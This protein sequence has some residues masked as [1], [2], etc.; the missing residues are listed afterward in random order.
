MQWINS[1][2]PDAS[3]HIAIQKIVP[4][5]RAEYCAL[6][7]TSHC[8]TNGAQHFVVNR[9]FLVNN[10][11]LVKCFS[12]SCYTKSDSIIES[13][14]KAFIAPKIDMKCCSKILSCFLY[15]AD[16]CGKRTRDWTSKTIDFSNFWYT[17]W[18]RTTQGEKKNQLHQMYLKMPEYIVGQA[19]HN[20]LYF[21]WF[22]ISQYWNG[23]VLEYI[24]DVKCD[25]LFTSAHW[26]HKSTINEVAT[27]MQ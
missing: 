17:L 7:H 10:S 21:V 27:D 15:I 1:R 9:I 6:Y 2:S 11:I 18:H 16:G 25:F 26:K 8:I 12:T 4:R 3:L 13:M 5:I 20:F 24:F 19:Q 22:T 23:F 14:N